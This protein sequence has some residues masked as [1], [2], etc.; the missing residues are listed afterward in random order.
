MIWDHNLKQKLT[1]MFAKKMS[2]AEVAKAMDMT[3]GKVA[4]MKHRLKLTSPSKPRRPKEV[5]VNKPRTHSPIAYV[6]Y[7]EAKKLEHV[8][9]DECVWPNF[10]NDLYCCGKVHKGRYCENHYNI[11]RRGK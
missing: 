11:S 2:N 8:G 9:V 7:G 3:I 5:F 6:M 10:G 4:G 1:T